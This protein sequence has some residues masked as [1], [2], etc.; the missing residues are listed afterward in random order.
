MHSP[1]LTSVGMRDNK[2]EREFSNRYCPEADTVQ[3]KGRKQRST[4]SPSDE[5]HGCYLSLR[6]GAEVGGDAGPQ[7]RAAPI[8]LGK[9]LPGPKSGSLEMPN[10]GFW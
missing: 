6:K 9:T 4:F 5:V 1:L 10:T 3:G 8:L 7:A 2:E